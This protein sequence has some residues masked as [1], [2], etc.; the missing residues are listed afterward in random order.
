[1]L[2][3]HRIDVVRRVQLADGGGDVCLGG[4][5]TEVHVRPA[6]PEFGGALLL[7]ADVAR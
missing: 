5:V 4:V 7:D 2:D 1:M 6:E 3:Q